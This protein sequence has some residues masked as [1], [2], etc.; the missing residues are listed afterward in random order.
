EC[1]YYKTTWQNIKSTA[2]DLVWSRFTKE[3]KHCRQK[4][5]LYKILTGL[6]EAN[7]QEKRRL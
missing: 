6:S 4:H 5:L 1:S 2:I 3:K 7:I